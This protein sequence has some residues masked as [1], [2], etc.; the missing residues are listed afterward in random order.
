[1]GEY[2][3]NG[4]LSELFNDKYNFDHNVMDKIGFLTEIAMAMRE[5]HEKRIFHRNLKASNVLL[6]N[7]DDIKLT[8][9]CLD[10]TQLTDFTH[11]LDA[12]ERSIRWMSPELIQTQ[13]FTTECDVY[14][15]G[16]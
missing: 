15:Y 10:V 11:S 13:I 6:S 14:A 9:Y 12:K 5:L 2:C 7:N 8:D 1:M 4:S 3:N 16:I